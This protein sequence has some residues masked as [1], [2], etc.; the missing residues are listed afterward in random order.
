MCHDRIKLIQDRL[1]HAC[2]LFREVR[3]SE[4]PKGCVAYSFP[5]GKDFACIFIDRNKKRKRLRRRAFVRF[6]HGNPWAHACALA[7]ER[8]PFAELR[9]HQ[10]TPTS[11]G[12][13]TDKSQ[14]TTMVRTKLTPRT[15]SAPE[16][17][18]LAGRFI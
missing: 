8:T 16:H 1:Y 7:H 10:C 15:T 11:S 14:M 4:I 13:P 17:T 2:K 5:H 12:D 6:S 9:K 18:S 3:V